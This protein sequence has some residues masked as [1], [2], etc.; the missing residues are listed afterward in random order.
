MGQ[1]LN[2]KNTTSTFHIWEIYEI[3]EHE[4][5]I[6]LFGPTEIYGFSY[7]SDPLDIAKKNLSHAKK[8]IRVFQHP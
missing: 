5:G 2:T 8:K 1:Y 3:Y 6:D 7:V 4:H